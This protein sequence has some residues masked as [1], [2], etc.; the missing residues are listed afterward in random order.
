MI[1]EVSEVSIA[2][3]VVVLKLIVEID[4]CFNQS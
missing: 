3:W 2:F 4:G 1:A